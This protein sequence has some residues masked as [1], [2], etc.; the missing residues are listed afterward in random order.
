MGRVKYMIFGHQK[1]LKIFSR[2]INYNRFPHAV[3][4]AGP[5]KIGKKTVA[6]EI[7]K[8]LSQSPTPKETFLDFSQKECSSQI[9]DLIDQ[10]NFPGILKVEKEE[11][12][13]IK[14]IR[15][16]RE[17]LSFSSPYP[18]KIVIIDNA[19]NL[20]WEATGALLKVLEEPRGKTIFFLV[21]RFPY[22]LPKT[23]LSRCEI[24]KFYPLSREEIKI[25]IKK[26]IEKKGIKLTEEK[27]NI[28][29]DFSAGRIGVA[30][31]I[32][33][34]KNRLFYYNLNLGNLKKIKN[35]SIFERMLM[36]EKLEKEEKI[37]DF[38]FIAEYWFR[39]LL[40]IK[41]KS[42]QIFFKSKEEEIKKESNFFSEEELKDILKKVQKT[43]KSLLFSNVS[44]LLA[45]ENFIL[46]I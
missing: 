16:I 46:G 13:S 30:K 28:I 24:F 7:S 34:D 36:A 9:C 10:G 11:D 40:L 45:V 32:L 41:N 33:L 19:E 26:E 31:D 2:L 37:D 22:V 3:L 5:S 20:L 42:K 23:I 38:L 25:F 29:L 43:K 39:D 35:I 21:A 17:K 4:F 12:F 6:I 8:Y 18:F 44:R 27:I 14:K 1:K 15:G